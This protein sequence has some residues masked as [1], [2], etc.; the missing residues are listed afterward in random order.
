LTSASPPSASNTY[1]YDNLGRV[2]TDTQTVSGLTPSVVM[3]STY[4]ANSRRTSLA[5]TIGGTADYK[6]DYTYDNLSR[7][8]QIVQQDVSGGNVVADKRVDFAYNALGQYTSV[9]RYQSTGTGTLVA[10]S[11]YAYDTRNRLTDLDHKQNSTNL[12]LY[13]YA[14]D[15]MDRITSM[16]HSVDGTSTFSYDKE[17]Q[18]T[19]ADHNTATDESYTYNATGNR[20]GGSYTNASNNRTTADATYSYTYDDEGNRS[21]R[22]KTSDSSYEDYTWDHRNRLTKV[23]FK[24]SGGTTLQTVEYAYDAFNRWVKRTH[25]ADGPGG[26]AATDIYFSGYD[27]INQSLQFSASAASNLDHRYLFNPD[28]VDQ[29]HAD[30]DVSSLGSAGNVLWALADHQGTV[31]DVVDLNEGTG[32]ASVT[33]H[34]FYDAFGNLK[35]E[36]NSAV[37]FAFGNQGKFYDETTK[38]NNHVFRWL[39]ALLGKWTSEDPSGFFAGDPSLVRVNGNDALNRIDPLGL[40][41]QYTDPSYQTS[42]G[43]YVWCDPQYQWWGHP[44]GTDVSTFTWSAQNHDFSLADIGIGLDVGMAAIAINLVPPWKIPVPQIPPGILPPA[45]AWVAKIPPIHIDSNITIAVGPGVTGGLI[46][47]SAPGVIIVT[48]YLG[49]GAGIDVSASTTIGFTPPPPGWN[50]HIQL[51]QWIGTLENTPF[52]FSGTFWYPPNVPLVPPF[53]PP[54]PPPSAQSWGIGMGWGHGSWFNTYVW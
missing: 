30:E 6:N 10:T 49:Y 44:D 3:T 25:D 32:V 39:D 9:T 20:T 42:D 27:G 15:A 37:D 34:R 38:L 28:V 31:R 4:N 47:T 36:S 45:P 19:A 48:P 2:L 51:D 24:N 22:T 41:A 8:T 14:Y 5:A 43:T 18:V 54:P 26:S 21:R 12:A 7:L 23:T 35:S 33:N 52:V 17:S 13:D 16:T 1:T 40:S 11:T 29:V 46:T 53:A 50:Q